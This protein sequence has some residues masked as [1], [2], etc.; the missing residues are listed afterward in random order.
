MLGRQPHSTRLLLTLAALALA[1]PSAL[2]APMSGVYTIG[3]AG[4]DFDS[5]GHAVDSLA[6]LG[7]S[8][9]VTLSLRTGSYHEAVT[10]PPVTG[11][12]AAHTITFQS[13]TGNRADVIWQFNPGHQGHVILLDGAD[14]VRI[15]NLTLAATTGGTGQLAVVR[16]RRQVD[17]VRIEGCALSAGGNNNFSS[18]LVYAS[19]TEADTLSRLAIANNLFSS[20]RGSAVRVNPAGS[21]DVGMTI[22]GN[23]IE[24]PLADFGIYVTGI[25]SVE[26]TD[27]R[28]EAGG[29]GI[30]SAGRFRHIER[31]RVLAESYGLFIEGGGGALPEQAGRVVN[32]MVAV[33]A[34]NTAAA[35][36][37][38]GNV[39]GLRVLHNTAVATSA[40]FAG[41]TAMRLND[42]TAGQGPY[43]V[44]N[45]IFIHTGAGTALRHT[46]A[47]VTG[48]EVDHNNLQSAGAN[49]AVWASANCVD[50]AALQAA[51]GLN[52]NSASVDVEFEAPNVDLHLCACSTADP[53]LRGIG[54]QGVAA[55][56]DGETRSATQPFMGADEPS[57]AGSDV[58]EPRAAYAVDRSW[59]FDHG[60][61]DGDGDQD[62]ALT[63]GPAEG[64][65]F[66]TIGRNDG[67]GHFTFEAPFTFANAWAW[68]IVAG[69]FNAEVDDQD[70]LAVLTTG[71]NGDSVWV[72]W[73]LE[74]GSF[75]TNLVYDPA[76]CCRP[77]DLQAADV[78]VDGD[79]DLNMI[80]PASPGFAPGIFPLLYVGGSFDYSAS[81]FT[82]STV[83][84][85]TW[86]RLADLDGD[87]LPDCVV[88]D[89]HVYDEEIA[90]HRNRG[91]D[92]FGEW[93]GFE[94]T[95]TRYQ[96]GSV[97][98]FELVDLDED[99]A[100]DLLA[101]DRTLTAESLSVA[102]NVGPGGFP[103][104]QAIDSGSYREPRRF[105]TMDYDYDR[106]RDIVT[107]NATGDLTLLLNDGTGAFQRIVGCDPTAPVASGFW[108]DMLSADFNGDLRPDLA[109]LHQTGGND[110]VSVWLNAG[111][112]SVAVRDGPRVP[113][114][115]GIRLSQN[116]ANPFRESTTI[117]FTLPGRQR[118]RLGVYDVQGR[119]VARLLDGEREAGEHRVTFRPDGLAGG[120]YFCVLRSGGE[121]Q[122][123]RMQ[124]IR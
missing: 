17:D 66:I 2:A 26:I 13:E 107:L 74:N 123:R 7:V 48:F 91:F 27:N 20:V 61:F 8:G 24:T 84:L 110:S 119:E 57:G 44:R 120:V 90:V 106:D 56:F 32:N 47:V 113:A 104:R 71:A 88:M 105:V 102:L 80:Y 25:D 62:L 12:S 40:A 5:I 109:V 60:D 43:V 89:D 75:Q 4:A 82:T 15:R 21:N 49:L 111:W 42:A 63:T 22:T 86:H 6:A 118:V 70:D 51:S 76:P 33:D 83:E 55:D 34:G 16:L 23:D 73:G 77:L 52:A 10:V 72:L 121:I 53:A 30:R 99:Y 1:A 35:I 97:V 29:M 81:Q 37:V 41:G 59:H 117:R 11:A 68:K 65:A 36:L 39:S 103:D 92:G 14:H 58:F 101:L 114:T 124:L 46:G 78:D 115:T 45:N 95:G 28:V 85:P 112:T 54:G 69:N 108:K 96:A 38:T 94:T 100:P 122:S 9:A 18:A 116:A 19:G 3:G 98:P 50:L 79:L 64:P 31:N 67:A 87:N 93:L